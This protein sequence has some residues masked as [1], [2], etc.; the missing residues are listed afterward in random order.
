MF[1]RKIYLSFKGGILGT[2][3]ISLLILIAPVLGLPRMPVW[4]TLAEIFKT[5]IFSG[6]VIHFAVGIFLAGLYI[7]WFKK[8]LLGR[9]AVRGMLFS[10]LPFILAQIASVLGQGFSFLLFLGS[11]IGHLAYGLVLGISTKEKI[12]AKTHYVCTGGCGGVSDKPGVCQTP[13]CAKFGHSLTPCNCV[14]GRHSGIVKACEK[15]G[16][17]C[18]GNCDIEVYKP[19]LK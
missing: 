18:E 19:E 4:E 5:S 10:L 13:H 2:I 6:W 17:L 15:C 7:F 9:D 16:K 11:L 8:R 12:F 1:R 14:D 3:A